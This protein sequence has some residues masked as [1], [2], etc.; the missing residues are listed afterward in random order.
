MIVGRCIAQTFPPRPRPVRRRAPVL[1]AR[2]LSAGNKLRDASF[3]LHKG[4]ILG[5]AGLQGMGQL[6]LFLA[7]FGMTEVK[8]GDIRVDGRKATI[9][10]P[11]DAMSRASIGLVPEDRKTEALFLKLDGRTT[12]R[13]R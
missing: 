13:C 12:P 10:S 7:C 1:S 5:V 8:S 11:V 6:D 4:E 9:T 3:D 2:N